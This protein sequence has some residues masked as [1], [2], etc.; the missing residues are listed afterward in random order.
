[1]KNKVFTLLTCSM[2]L[3]SACGANNTDNSV[4]TETAEE[5]ES[6][7]T[8]T[9][10][11][12]AT[13]AETGEVLSNSLFSITMPAELEGIYEAEVEDQQITLYH[14]ESKDAGFNGMAYTIW[15]RE[16]PPEFYGG[17]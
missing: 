14:K 8:Q 11:D 3:L 5:V 2:L 10:E 12:D 13:A 17:P 16:M 15:A 7:E 6:A 9:T 4:D 1:M